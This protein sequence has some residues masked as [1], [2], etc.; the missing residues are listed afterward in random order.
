MANDKGMTGD[1]VVWR[2]T[3]FC[4]IITPLPAMGGPRPLLDHHIAPPLQPRAACRHGRGI[5]LAVTPHNRAFAA[6]S[7]QPSY[8][9]PPQKKFLIHRSDLSGAQ[10]R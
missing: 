4:Q 5:S 3:S 2:C 9:A 6:A 7:T 8:R 1:P 10:P